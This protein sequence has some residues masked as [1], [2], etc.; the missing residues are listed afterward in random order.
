MS[1]KELLNL[2]GSITDKNKTIDRMTGKNFNIFNITNIYHDEVII[3]R[4]IYDLLSPSGTHGQGN[5]F[6]KLFLKNIL[7]LDN[8]ISED[9]LSSVKVFREYMIDN[10]RRID[11]VI[12]TKSHFIPIEVK[13]FA[14][15]QESQ[16][17]D[18]YKRAINSPV[19]YLTRF[20]EEPSRYSTTDKNS[21][22]D[23]F[24]DVKCLSFETDIIDWL[25]DC[26]KQQETIRISSIRE[27]II[28]FI[29]AIKKFT[30]N[31]GDKEMEEI[32]QLI[33]KNKNVLKNSITI[34]KALNEL[35]PEIMRELFDRVK[36]KIE[37]NSLNNKYDY[38]FNTYNKVNSYFINKNS[39]YPGISYK[40]NHNSYSGIDV[41]AWVRLEI[42]EE[43]YVGVCF[44]KNNEFAKCTLS[45]KE[46]SKIVNINEGKV[47]KNGW[48][49][50]SEYIPNSPNFKKY[51]DS[52]YNLLDDKY[53]ESLST[54]I[55]DKIK[56]LLNY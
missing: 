6:L 26:L 27:I 33:S 47:R 25:E 5:K 48:W 18:Y 34:Q 21:N 3:C 20:G 17:F 45:N 23:A 37:V 38:S 13:I 49:G 54:S 7:A 10:N 35:L 11:L 46:I 4:V 14:G 41:D 42:K 31:L 15:D 51:N 1:A 22:K 39:T 53:L 9:E 24:E 12:R 55:A 2:V 36:S 56:I 50:C 19:F 30:Y 52:F 28:Q 8:P 40:L 43:I 32:K 44:P 29:E 16:C